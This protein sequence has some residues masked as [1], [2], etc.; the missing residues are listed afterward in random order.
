MDTS[1]KRFKILDATM[2][3]HG[4]AGDAL[5]E[6]LHSA[7]Q[8]YGC[9]DLDILQVI[10]RALKLPTSKVYGV[11]TFYNIFS[12]KPRGEHTCIVCT[13]TACYIKGAARILAAIDGG[14]NL[15]PGV[16]TKDNKVSLLQARCFGSC[17][18][19]PAVS[20]DG[21]VVGRNEPDGVLEHLR[22]WLAPASVSH[23]AAISETP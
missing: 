2:R 4:Y 13:G 9:L 7:Q 11:A 23:S 8:L 17:A 10:A 16:T 14:L 19:A 5:I 18:Q 12:F 20:F 6:S 15:K 22:V 3:R 21:T 1:D